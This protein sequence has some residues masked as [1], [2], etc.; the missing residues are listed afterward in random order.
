[1]SLPNRP[2]TFTPARRRYGAW[3]WVWAVALLLL[4]LAAWRLQR[5]EETRRGTRVGRTDDPPAAPRPAWRELA[6]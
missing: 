4:L 6:Q 3:R 5:H 1:M 2:V